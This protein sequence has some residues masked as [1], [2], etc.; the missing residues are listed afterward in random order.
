[1]A[2]I[3]SSLEQTPL[4]A[5]QFHETNNRGALSRWLA[6][7]RDITIGLHDREVISRAATIGAQSGNVV[8]DVMLT[9]RERQ[10]SWP[11]H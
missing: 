5:Q 4:R 3:A 1:M 9:A 6:I 11:A 2:A 7:A 8:R 10:L